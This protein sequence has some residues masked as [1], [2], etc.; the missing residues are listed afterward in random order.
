MKLPTEGEINVYNSPDEIAARDH[1]LNK[2]LDE[3][4]VLFKANS[5]YYQE[6]LM[7]MGPSAF[8]FYLQAAINYVKSDA[9]TGDSQFIHALYE[10]ANFRADQDGFAAAVEALKTLADY[11][12]AN[13]DKFHVDQE[14]YGDLRA[15]YADLRERLEHVGSQPG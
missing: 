5:A 15:Q 7:W 14:T 4:E 8:A 10:I 13:F 12:I 6:D 9:S 2:T 3:A 11:V 1:F